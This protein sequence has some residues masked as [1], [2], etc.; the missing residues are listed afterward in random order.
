MCNK[1]AKSNKEQ[2]IELITG[3]TIEQWEENN[4]KLE[5][6][7]NKKEEQKNQEADIRMLE[8]K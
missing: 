2:V 4:K 8:K 3:I 7:M 1:L 5:E 6:L